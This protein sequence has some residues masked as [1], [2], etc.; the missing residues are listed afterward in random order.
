M[1]RKILNH[2]KE[3]RSGYVLA[4]SSILFISYSTFIF[5]RSDLSWSDTDFYKGLHP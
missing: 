1:L 4:I 5:S 3:F 2:V